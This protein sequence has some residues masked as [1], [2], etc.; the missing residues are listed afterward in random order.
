MGTTDGNQAAGLSFFFFICLAVPRRLFRLA[1]CLV[2]AWRS[3]RSALTIVGTLES[4]ERFLRFLVS[5]FAT[6]ARTF[7]TALPCDSLTVRV[8]PESLI[9]K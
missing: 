5:T 6:G 9:R 3:F 2:D 8:L 4:L 1:C 7:R